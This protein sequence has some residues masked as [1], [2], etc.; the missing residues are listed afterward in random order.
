MKWNKPGRRKQ[1]EL[2]WKMDALCT[3]TVLYATVII[4][5]IIMHLFIC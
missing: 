3:A 2:Y 4:I 5:I 1:V